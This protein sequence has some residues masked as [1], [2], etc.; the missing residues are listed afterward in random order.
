MR[1]L[2]RWWRGRRGWSGTNGT[3]RVYRTNWSG[4]T[5]AEGIVGP[6][7][8][9]GPIGLIGETGPTGP[10][11]IIGPTGTDGLSI[12]GPTGALGPTGASTTGTLTFTEGTNIASAANID[13]Y[14]ISNNSFFKIIGTTSSSISGLANGV[15]GRF[16]IIVN[17]TDK[18]QTFQ[19]EST[20]SLASNRF[21]LG[22]ANKTIGVN[23]TVSF[24][25]VTGLTVGG[26]GSQ[27]RWVMTA[28]T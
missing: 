9:T 11:G 1:R 21:V 3:S 25:Y 4:P 23:Q 18:N 2:W 28:T 15:S 20:A 17:N 16:I 5:G 12:T 22:V 13:N 27:S 10:Q 8:S 24:I 14:N 6:T 19:Q 7:G 26:I